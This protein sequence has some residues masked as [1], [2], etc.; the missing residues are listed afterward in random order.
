MKR[1]VI[2]FE[3]NEVPR[4]VIE[5]F[6]ASRPD[7][8]FARVC[9]DGL[10]RE[11]V[12]PDAV[13]S[14]WI[15]WPTLHRGAADHGIRHFGQD[16]SAADAAH[17]PLWA[18]AMQAGLRV[19]VF[20]SLHSWP[21]PA[22]VSR[23]AFYVPDTFAPEAQSHPA[24]LEAFQRFNLAMSRASARNVAGGVPAREALR[25][26]R[27]APGLGLRTRT[28]AGLA[29]Q[30]AA[31][32]IAPWKRA[33]RRTW[34]SV[35]AFDL[36]EK[37]L[38]RSLPDFATFFTNHVASAQHRYWAAAFPGDYERV[39]QDAAWLNRYRGE[40]AFAMQHAEN[41]MRRLMRY[42]AAK[43]ERLLVV[44]SSMGQSATVAKPIRTQLYLRDVEKFMAAL[45]VQRWER[46]PAMDPD[47]S[48]YVE[49]AEEFEQA[50]KT[51]SIAGSPV[52]YERGEGGFFSLSFGHEDLPDDSRF[53]EL[54]L[55]NESIE[56][57]AA[58]TAYHI[59]QGALLLWSA[60]PL[61]DVPDA[62]STTEVAPRILNWL[63]DA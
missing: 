42:T 29:A 22:D 59:P 35:I 17:P 45:G 13:L 30:L 21:P 54:G 11:T 8:A 2:L 41:M 25:F 9:R 58:T 60:G 55:V 12:A 46:R 38:R 4:R 14:P 63:S 26:L 23:Y 56:D 28:L 48:L 16:L 37:A 32:R 7:G 52:Q 3:L 10:L 31:E 20:G 18:R 6:A 47:V 40:V 19:G 34:Q 50:L 27:A 15:T 33:R 5:D 53:A 36:F 62:L 43:P 51:L 61:P 24:A 44:A 39:K 57:A 1:S 49:N